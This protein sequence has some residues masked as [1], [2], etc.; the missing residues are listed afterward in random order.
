[1]DLLLGRAGVREWAL[2]YAYG[3]Y[4]SYGRQR[5]SPYGVAGLQAARSPALRLV[6]IHCKHKEM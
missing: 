1:M 6:Q 2:C 3:S 4:G 5:Y